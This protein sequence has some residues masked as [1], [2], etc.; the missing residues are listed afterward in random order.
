MCSSNYSSVANNFKNVIY[1]AVVQ[2]MAESV[3]DRDASKTQTVKT[4]KT[5]VQCCFLSRPN[6]RKHDIIDHVKP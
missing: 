1:Q 2:F 6:K 3:A 4:K 5:W